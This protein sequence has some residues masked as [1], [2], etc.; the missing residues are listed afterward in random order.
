MTSDDG[1]CYWCG[2][3]CTNGDNYTDDCTRDPIKCAAAAAVK[4]NKKRDII[5]A[6]VVGTGV[7]NVSP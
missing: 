5:K 6:H 1:V 2:D 7:I 3:K 4:A